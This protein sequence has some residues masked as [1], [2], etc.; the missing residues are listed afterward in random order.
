MW[1]RDIYSCMALGIMIWALSAES[2]GS[3]A[4][5]SPWPMAED[6]PGRNQDHQSKEHQYPNPYDEM[7]RRQA[8]QLSAWCTR[9]VRQQAEEQFH[10]DR[11]SFSFWHTVTTGDDLFSYRETVRGS[12]RVKEGEHKRENYPYSCAIEGDPP[13][14]IVSIGSS[15]KQV[16]LPPELVPTRSQPI[17]IPRDPV[18]IPRMGR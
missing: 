14:G 13:V 1:R 3:Q 5:G 10:T 4:R 17:P 2:Y 18:P 15:E 8:A 16:P 7:R 12:F 9:V 6:R 11:L